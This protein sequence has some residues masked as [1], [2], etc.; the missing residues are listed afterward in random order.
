[1]WSICQLECDKTPLHAFI[2]NY[3]GDVND[4][5]FGFVYVITNGRNDL[6]ISLRLVDFTNSSTTTRANCGCTSFCSLVY[7]M[8]EQF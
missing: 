7:P 4:A 3:T 1:M 6:E 8:H 5:S 2:Y